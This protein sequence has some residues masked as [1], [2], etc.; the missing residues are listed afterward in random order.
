V[1]KIFAAEETTWIGPAMGAAGR[2]DQGDQGVDDLVSRNY[3][4][5][6]DEQK[7]G[8]NNSSSSSAKAAAT[9]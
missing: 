7:E 1:P 5:G 2:S 3:Q 4:L 9:E 8:N 6:E